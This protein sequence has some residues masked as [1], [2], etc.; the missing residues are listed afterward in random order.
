MS[1]ADRYD[2]AYERP[3][4]SVWNNISQDA[5]ASKIALDTYA[6]TTAS[7]TINLKT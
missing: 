7:H 6:Q 1:E 5:R 2:Q 3:P 4:I